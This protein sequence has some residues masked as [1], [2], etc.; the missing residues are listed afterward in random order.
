[1]TSGDEDNFNEQEHESKSGDLWG[2]LLSPTAITLAVLSFAE[3]WLLSRQMR[4]LLLSMPFV[5]TC[6]FF[7][8]LIAQINDSELQLE[9]RY[10]NM[11]SE[12]VMNEDRDAQES[13]LRSLVGLNP[14]DFSLQVQLI[15]VLRSMVMFRN[16][17]GCCS[18]CC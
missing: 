7:A 8:V 11:L 18:H 15:D 1:M 4:L 3:G 9:Q 5:F 2:V 6:F 10:R 13:V 17:P 12:S 16:R 14:Q